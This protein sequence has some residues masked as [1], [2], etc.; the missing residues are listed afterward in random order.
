MAQT[1]EGE[2]DRVYER[3]PGD[4]VPKGAEV[5]DLL[6]CSS[7]AGSKASLARELPKREAFC[8]KGER[9]EQSPCLLQ[10]V[11]LVRTPQ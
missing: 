4:A 1:P 2:S 10:R 8:T 3:Y 11:T 5:S 9:E 6:S 7:R